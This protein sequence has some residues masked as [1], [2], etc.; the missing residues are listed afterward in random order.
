MAAPGEARREGRAA[1]RNRGREA[2]D[3]AQRKE[4][5]NEKLIYRLQNISHWA[6]KVRKKF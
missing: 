6:T 1:T 5:R 2:L 4:N 3:N